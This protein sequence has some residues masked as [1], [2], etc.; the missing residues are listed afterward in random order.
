M[1]S[2]ATSDTD[3]LSVRNEELA[4]APAAAPPVEAEATEPACPRCGA[5]LIDPQGLGWCSKC[6]YCRTLAEE[7]PVAM[8]SETAVTQQPSPL[9]VL[10][11]WDMMVRLPHWLK[12]LLCGMGVVAVLSLFARLLF[13][14]GTLVRALCCTLELMF[15]L[16]GL[17]LAQAWALAR[18]APEED[19]LGPKDIF[20]ATKLWKLT[21]HRLPDTHK[22]VWL[23]GWSVTAGLCSVFLVGGFSYWAQFYQPQ[24]IASK[25]LLGAVRDAENGNDKSLTEA[26]EDFA[27]KQD[28]TKKKDDPLEDD[29]AV[30]NRPRVQCVVIGYM[31]SNKQLSG[32]VLGMLDN[33]RLSYAG[34]VEKGLSEEQSKDILQKLATAVRPTPLI[35]GLNLSAIWVKPELFC[36]VHHSGTD[37]N[38]KLIKPRFAALLTKDY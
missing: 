28:L 35:K 31:V 8:V 12:V 11:F 24:K 7:A 29:N 18:I 23:G 33:E 38:G 6:G 10:E 14:D 27:D 34:T 5:K 15:S 17:V 36:E 9:G 30:D 4:K 21:F 2:P 20:F 22:Q 3:T 32:L 37:E 25:E 1:D 16:V 13:L 19:S 26:V